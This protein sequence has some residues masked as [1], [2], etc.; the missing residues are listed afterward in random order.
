MKIRGPDGI[1]RNFRIPNLTLD[2]GLC[3]D[4]GERFG[5]S[6][7]KILKLRFKKHTCIKNPKVAATLTPYHGH[8]KL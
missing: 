4:C 7:T 8:K 3:E 2:E 6:D 1:V 5:C